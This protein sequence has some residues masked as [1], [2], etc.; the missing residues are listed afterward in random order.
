V[1]KE[2][3]LKRERK[4]LWRLKYVIYTMVKLKLKPIVN[5][6]AWTLTEALDVGLLP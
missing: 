3:S 6:S 5:C 4:Y 1:R 2:L